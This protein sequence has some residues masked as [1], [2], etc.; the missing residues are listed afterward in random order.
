MNKNGQW[1]KSDFLGLVMGSGGIK[2]QEEKV[3]KVLE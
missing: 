1:K 2:M 3:V